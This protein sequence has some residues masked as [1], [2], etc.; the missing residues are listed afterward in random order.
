MFWRVLVFE[1]TILGIPILVQY[2]PDVH[3]QCTSIFNTQ[4]DKS[5]RSSIIGDPKE[6]KANFIFENID[7]KA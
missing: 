2:V 4:D 6:L 1:G 7:L 3:I 5:K